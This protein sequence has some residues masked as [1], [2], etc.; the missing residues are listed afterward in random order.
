MKQVDDK[1]IIPNGHCT[2]HSFLRIWKC[3]RSRLAFIS[4]LDFFRTF[5]IYK[6]HYHTYFFI[7]HH[8]K[9]MAHKIEFSIRNFKEMLL[10]FHVCP[11]TPVGGMFSLLKVKLIFFNWF[12]TSLP[13]GGID[14]VASLNIVN[15]PWNKI[16]DHISNVWHGI[17]RYM[18]NIQIF[19]IYTSTR[20]IT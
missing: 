6:P 12:N 3:L 17:S 15:G 4:S 13:K 1:Y 16:F 9:I 19:H 20:I 2:G 11:R 14:V 7:M 18:K 5:N 10:F 8:I